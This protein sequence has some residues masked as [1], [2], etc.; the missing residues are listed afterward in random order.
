MTWSRLPESR[1][2]SAT[3]QSV[4]SSRP[5]LSS[6]H[7]SRQD[8]IGTRAFCARRCLLKI[9]ARNL[10][11][12]NVALWLAE[13]R[14]FRSS[15]ITL[16]YLPSKPHRRGSRISPTPGC[17]MSSLWASI[18]TPRLAFFTP[19]ARIRAARGRVAFLSVPPRT[20]V[21]S[22]LPAGG[23]TTRCCALVLAPTISCVWPRS[24]QRR[25]TLLGAPSPSF[26]STR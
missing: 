11:I 14:P 6:G 8:L 19:N 18:R 23:E 13:R 3:N 9:L 12:E 7:S 22:T 1:T 17:W 24:T 16:A 20:T 4:R 26:G 10:R 2:R 15:G 25:S 5:G 21:L